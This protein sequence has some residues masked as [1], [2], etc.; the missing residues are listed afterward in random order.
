MFTK[1]QKENIRTINLFEEFY[2]NKK[3]VSFHNKKKVHIPDV[4]ELKEQVIKSIIEKGF[5]K[6]ERVEPKNANCIIRIFNN[7]KVEF[8]RDVMTNIYGFNCFVKEG[9]KW[10]SESCNKFEINF[11]KYEVGYWLCPDE[12]VTYDCDFVDFYVKISW[13]IKLKR[14]NNPWRVVFCAYFLSICS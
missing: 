2:G 9:G 12:Y 6:V 11:E 1:E 3:G 14:K 5:S 4:W 13:R 7:R 8:G 10:I